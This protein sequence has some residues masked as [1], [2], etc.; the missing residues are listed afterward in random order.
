M[1]AKVKIEKEVEL[2]TLV[3]KAGVRYWEDT[4]VNGEIDTEE[5]DNIPCK[6]G[7]LWC[8]EIDIDS[9]IIINW[10]QGVKADVHYKACDCFGYEIKSDEGVVVVSAEDGYVPNTMCPKERGYGDYIIMEINEYGLISNW[11]FDFS[12]FENSED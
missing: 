12:D 8:P 1:K 9:G 11:K 10:K 7:N 6:V 4:E 5:G 3:V 2:K